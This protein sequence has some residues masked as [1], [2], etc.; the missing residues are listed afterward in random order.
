MILGPV[1]RTCPFFIPRLL[2]V[3][4]FFQ[5]ACEHLSEDFV[6]I[7]ANGAIGILSFQRTK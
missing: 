4:D 7:E 6:R 3:K 1:A 2:L 5:V